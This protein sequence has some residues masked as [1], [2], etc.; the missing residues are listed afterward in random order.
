MEFLNGVSILK[1]MLY[2]N[3]KESAKSFMVMISTIQLKCSRYIS[4]FSLSI[5][6]LPFYFPLKI[7]LA[8][9]KRFPFP[10]TTCLYNTY[11]KSGLRRNKI[12]NDWPFI[13][14]SDPFNKINTMTVTTPFIPCVYADICMLKG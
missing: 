9:A 8:Y 7:V 4:F 3:F 11:H 2:C 10:Y 12:F 5:T 1:E 6:L 14:F 13:N